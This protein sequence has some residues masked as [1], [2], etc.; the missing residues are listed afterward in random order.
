MCILVPG[1]NEVFLDL[2]ACKWFWNSLLCPVLL[3]A[4]PHEHSDYFSVI[5]TGFCKKFKQL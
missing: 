5:F 4:L 1:E 3:I 2:R